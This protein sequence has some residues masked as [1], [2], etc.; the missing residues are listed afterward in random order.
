MIA[1]LL[2]PKVAYD[3]VVENYFDPDTVFLTE[4][5]VDISNL[6]LTDKCIADIELK[7]SKVSANAQ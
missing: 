5:F 4:K 2:S 7:F 3:L 1:Y 6:R